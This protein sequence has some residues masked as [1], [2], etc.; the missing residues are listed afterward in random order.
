V[1][2]DFAVSGM[3]NLGTAALGFITGSMC[4]G[5]GTAGTG[6]NGYDCLIIPGAEKPTANAELTP[7][8]FCGRSMGLVTLTSGT[9]AATICSK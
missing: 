9:P 8:M 4:C 3:S 5:Y 6:T 1:D 7:D 2:T